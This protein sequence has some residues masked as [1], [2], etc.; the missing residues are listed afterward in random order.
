MNLPLI[1]CYLSGYFLVGFTMIPLIWLGWIDEE[2]VFDY[3]LGILLVC[4]LVLVYLTVKQ[5]TGLCRKLTGKKEK[6]TEYISVTV[7]E[8]DTENIKEDNMSVTKKLD[9][10]MEER[11][12]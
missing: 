1:I 7:E 5:L 2:D 11:E 3:M 8:Q 4:L 12:E 10:F 9:R 6:Y